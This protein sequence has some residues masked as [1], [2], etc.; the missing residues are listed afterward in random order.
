MSI[1][2]ERIKTDS[3]HASHDFYR[4]DEPRILPRRR[5]FDHMAQWR[6]SDLEL[7]DIE[8][9]ESIAVKRSRVALYRD[10]T[11]W[12]PAGIGGARGRLDLWDVAAARR[13]QSILITHN[14]SRL[15]HL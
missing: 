7:E 13:I 10:G 12:E 8:S 3:V 5:A 6:H 11:K 14:G 15:P 2:S 1:R 4:R 9:D